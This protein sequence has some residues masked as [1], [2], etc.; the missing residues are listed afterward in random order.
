MIAIV[1]KSAYDTDFLILTLEAAG[2]RVLTG[3]VFAEI[4]QNDLSTEIIAGFAIIG[5][6]DESGIN[7]LRSLM[8]YNIICQRVALSQTQ[9]VSIIRNA[10]NRAHVNYMLDY[11]AEKNELERNLKKVIRRYNLL[12]TPFKKFDLLSEVTEDLLDQNEKYRIEAT[13]DPLT[14]L[15]NRRSFNKMIQRFWERWHS[16]QVLFCLAFLDL[17]FFKKVN[18]TYG[19]DAGDH[20]LR[21]VAAILLSNQRDGLDFAFRYGG[22][23]F[24]ILSLTANQQEME[25]FINRISDLIRKT[26]IKIN[27]ND[28]INITISAGIC[29]SNLVQQVDELIKNADLA[30]Y[31]AKNNGRDQVVVY[32][33]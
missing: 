29:S 4:M 11:P 5:D 9:N 3:R 14:K 19:H 2:F 1:H 31:E 16:K 28:Q 7:F 18:D 13:I 32:N 15:L 30:L 33:S 12:N 8:E 23:E 20:V 26:I 24:T 27:E 22:E 17:D 10:I 25:L 6:E 21:T